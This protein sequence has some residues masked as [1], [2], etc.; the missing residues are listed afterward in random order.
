MNLENAIGA[1]LLRCFI[2]RMALPWRGLKR[3]AS[4]HHWRFQTHLLGEILS[5][6]KSEKPAGILEMASSTAL[7]G[8]ISQ[9]SCRIAIQRD[10]ALVLIDV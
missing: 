3:L 1:H 6:K 9:I 2:P 7:F 8:V 10:P 4:A 5:R